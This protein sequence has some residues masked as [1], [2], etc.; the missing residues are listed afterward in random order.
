Q[1]IDTPSLDGTTTLI[2]NPKIASIL[3]T[4]GP[5][6]VN[7][8]L[9][10]GNPSMG[11]GAGNGAVFV[12]GTANVDRAVEDLLLSKRFD[13]GMICATENSLVIE[14]P[15]YDE[16]MRKLQEQGAYLTP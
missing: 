6:M 3:A 7:A 14:A 9:K 13:N 5:S 12:D 16:V 15:V 11:V 2:Q 1:W 4:G 8:A 10:S